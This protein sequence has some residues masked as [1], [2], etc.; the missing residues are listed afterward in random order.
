MGIDEIVDLKVEIMCSYLDVL[1]SLNC[2]VHRVW[3]HFYVDR[4]IG[5]CS[6]FRK[7]LELTCNWD[8]VIVVD[9]D[10]KGSCI[11]VNVKGEMWKF[12]SEFVLVLIV[13]AFRKKEII[14]S[15]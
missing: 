5:E 10:E 8:A 1:K 6:E 11:V 12:E 14:V 2:T 9:S 3:I 4:E 13:C 15:S 7:R